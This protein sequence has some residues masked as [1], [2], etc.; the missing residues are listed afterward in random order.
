MADEDVDERVRVYGTEVVGVEYV[1]SAEREVGK[2]L[3]RTR[4]SWRWWVEGWA[5]VLGEERDKDHASPARKRV[6]AVEIKAPLDEAEF[7]TP[8]SFRL[9][10]I[11]EADWRS[12]VW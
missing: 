7:S 10:K 1:I 6:F 2:S 4:V 9:E 8:M 12:S 3:R 5:V 11:V